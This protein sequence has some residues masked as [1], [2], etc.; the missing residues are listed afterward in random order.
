MKRAML[1]ILALISIS[2]LLGIQNRYSETFL[3]TRPCYERLNAYEAFWQNMTF[4]QDCFPHYNMQSIFF[5]QNSIN[6]R[7]DQFRQYFLMR[8]KNELSVKGDSVTTIDRDIRA[9]WLQLPA[10]YIGSFTMIPEQEQF[11]ALFVARK[12]L[13]NVFHWDFLDNLW[14]GAQVPIAFVKNKINFSETSTLTPTIFSKLS[15]QNYIYDRIVQCTDSLGFTELELMFGAHFQPANSLQIGTRTG[16]IVPLGN[17]YDGK[18]FYEAIRGYNRHLAWETTVNTQVPLNCSEVCNFLLYMDFQSILLFPNNQRRT[19]DLVDRPWSRYLLMVTDTGQINVPGVNLLTPEVKVKPFNL[20][21]VCA[22]FR[23]KKGNLEVQLGF[24]LWAHGN[25]E[26][27]LKEPWRANFGI[28]APSGTTPLGFPATASKSTI[29]TLA[30]TD[31]DINGDPEFVP[32]LAEDLDFRSGVSRGTY[33][34]GIEL[35]IGWVHNHER[36][37]GFIGAGGFVDFPAS[38]AALQLWGIWFKFGGSV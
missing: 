36:V 27:E 14:V 23:V 29:K 4:Y 1:F 17:K 24:D 9:E 11:G 34:T 31:T 12:D 6:K 18:I 30:P 8:D 2:N 25:E 13:K 16:L 35:A 26:V 15:S 19:F 37:S 22:G 38:N 3:Y 20:I 5:Y 21:D 7:D 28:A 33:T 10:D 32:I